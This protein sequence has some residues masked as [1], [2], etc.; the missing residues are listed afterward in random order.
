MGCAQSTEEDGTELPDFKEFSVLLLD[1]MEQVIGRGIVSIDQT[2]MVF[3]MRGESREHI[4]ELQ[5]LRRYGADGR[6]FSFE[7][8]RNCTDGEGIWAFSLRKADLL[9]Q[10]VDNFL[11]R[12]KPQNDN[13]DN[14]NNT[15]TSTTTTSTSNSNEKT[16]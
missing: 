11:Q 7:A 4:W 8:G 12:A 10:M 3:V 1:N 5:H 9:H 13:N 16:K 2:K 6:F 14:S 15:Q